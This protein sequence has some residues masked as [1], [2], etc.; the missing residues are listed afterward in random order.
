LDGAGN[1]SREKHLLVEARFFETSKDWGKAIEAYQT[2]FSF[3][4]DNLEYGLQLASVETAGGRGKDALKGLASLKCFWRAGQKAIRESIWPEQRP[5]RRSGTTDSP[6]TRQTSRHKKQGNGAR[7]SWW[8]EPEP[9]SA[10]LWANLGENER[11]SLLAKKRGR[12]TPLRETAARWRKPCTPWL[13]FPS[14]KGILLRPEA[15]QSSFDDNAG[16]R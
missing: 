1:L 3:F 13:K 11:P 9:G 12:S 6:E 16:H 14:T 5:L 10:G 4:P 8:L 2:L 15:L 7:H